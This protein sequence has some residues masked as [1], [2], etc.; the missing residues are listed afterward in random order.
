MRWLAESAPHL[1]ALSLHRSAVSTLTTV[2]AGLP[3]RLRYPHTRYAGSSAAPAACVCT[4]LP[5]F[6]QHGLCSRPFLQVMVPL[7][8]ASLRCTLIHNP[9]WLPATT[10]FPSLPLRLMCVDFCRSAVADST[11]TELIVSSSH[12]RALPDSSASQW[13]TESIC[14]C[15]GLRCAL[16]LGILIGWDN[17]AVSAFPCSEIVAFAPTLRRLDV[18]ESMAL[19]A[20]LPVLAQVGLFWLSFCARYSLGGAG[21]QTESFDTLFC[22]N[23]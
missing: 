12:L 13:L 3:T 11:R 14:L 9:R 20:V 19:G 6:I 23:V 4:S 7:T 16:C 21:V 5:A 10:D 8:R 18:R 2:A 22:H 17:R 1:D 15:K